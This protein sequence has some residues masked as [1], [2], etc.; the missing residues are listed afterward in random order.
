MKCKVFFIAWLTAIVASAASAASDGIAEKPIVRGIT[1]GGV[2]SASDRNVDYES[3]KESHNG[4][5]YLGA[6]FALNFANFKNDYHCV[7]DMGVPDPLCAFVRGSDSYSFAQQLGFDMRAGYQFAPKWRAELNYGYTGAFED[8]GGAFK[9]A[10]SSQ[11]IMANALYTIRQW[12]TTSVY[13]GPGVGAAFLQSR[14][15]GIAFLPD[16]KD[17]QTKATY[18][19]QLMLGVEEA[20]TPEF[21]IGLSYRLMYNGGM[22]N[23]REHVANDGYLDTK[24]GNVLTNSLMLGARF[25]F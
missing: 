24:I 16:G 18:A 13:G 2:Q 4:N 3:K 5:F 19:G 14:M 7:S 11:Y 12:T 8:S 1:Y 10:L 15:A 25:K 22:T 23:R 20:L 9:F 6:D 17:T 21:F